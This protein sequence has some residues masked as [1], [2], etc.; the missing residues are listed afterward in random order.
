MCVCV[1]EER[2]LEFVRGLSGSVA[3]GVSGPKQRWMLI[4]PCS[5]VGAFL[6]GKY[7]TA[8]SRTKR[9]THL[10]VASLH[11]HPKSISNEDLIDF[12]ILILQ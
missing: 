11:R 3:E 7:N 2:A 6:G 10:S 4:I 5:L 1:F 9:M 12:L 8:Q